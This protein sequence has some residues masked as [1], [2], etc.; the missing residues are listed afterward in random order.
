MNWRQ[1]LFIS[2]AVLLVALFQA[3]ECSGV[4]LAGAGQHYQVQ[5][6]TESSLTPAMR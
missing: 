3:K 6:L 5:S 4:L 2:K 1:K